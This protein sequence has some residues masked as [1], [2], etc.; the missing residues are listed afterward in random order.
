MT[1]DS[2]SR[3]GYEGRS[4][5]DLQG[6]QQSCGLMENWIEQILSVR[7]SGLLSFESNVGAASLKLLTC[8]ASPFQ[9]APRSYSSFS[10]GLRSTHNRALQSP[11]QSEIKI[12]RSSSTPRCCGSA[13]QAAALSRQR[14][15]R[16]ASMN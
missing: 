12:E 14:R 4:I 11:A 8:L 16:S 3:L 13:R 9:Q 1:F 6:D 5:K 2:D 15:I 7:I 10:L